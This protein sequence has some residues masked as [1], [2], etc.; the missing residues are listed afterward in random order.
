MNL[1]TGTLA[2]HVSA[3][4][5]AWGEV[6]LEALSSEEFIALTADLGR[7]RRA[8]EHAETRVAGELAHRST[9]H[10]EADGL[11]RRAGHSK[12]GLF[13]AELWQVNPAEGTR[14]CAVG[15]ATRE[16]TALDGS[17]L[18]ARYPALG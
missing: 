2:T 8:L 14:L 15:E 7:V 3:F 12:P 10:L 16:V 4:A 13:L 17:P 1:S 18:P 6:D 5:S 9:P 11:A